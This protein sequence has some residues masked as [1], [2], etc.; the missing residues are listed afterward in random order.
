MIE[1]GEAL[2]DQIHRSKS[3]LSGEVDKPLRGL[4]ANKVGEQL[5][6]IQSEIGGIGDDLLLA[7]RIGIVRGLSRRRQG[8]SENGDVKLAPH[9]FHH[10]GGSAAG[11]SK[12]QNARAKI[13]PKSV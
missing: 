11:T 8:Y 6:V 13:A 3:A 2:D 7:S 4:S 9:K 10:T 12:T 5:L 1:I